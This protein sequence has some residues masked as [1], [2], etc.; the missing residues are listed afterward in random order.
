MIRCLC[1]RSSQF[2]C[3]QKLVHVFIYNSCNNDVTSITQGK[4]FKIKCDTISDLLSL[5][6]KFDPSINRQC[7]IDYALCLYL[8]NCTKNA[9]S[10]SVLVL[11]K[12]LN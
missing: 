6:D 4:S 2:N 9:G 10:S 5:I 8:V 12:I 3:M 7:Q 11:K 1:Q